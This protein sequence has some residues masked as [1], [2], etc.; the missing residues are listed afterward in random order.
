MIDRQSTFTPATSTPDYIIQ[1]EP[2]PDGQGLTSQSEGITR[3]LLWVP[4]SPCLM[5]TG[6]SRT[7]KDYKAGHT[8][9]SKTIV[10]NG[11]LSPRGFKF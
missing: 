10:N 4:P 11:I 3:K 1:S 2:S 9:V 8:V 6:L 7:N 5:M